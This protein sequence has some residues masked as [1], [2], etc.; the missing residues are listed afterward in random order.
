MEDNNF[1]GPFWERKIRTFFK[2]MDANGDGFV[3]KQDYQWLAGKYAEHGQLNYVQAKQV[4]RKLEKIWDDFYEKNSKNGDSD[5]KAY[6]KS[7]KERKSKLFEMCQ[8][9]HG[10]FFDLIDL[11]GDG[12]VQSEEFALF[13]KVFGIG[14]ETVA[15]ESFKKLDTNADGKLSH[16]E[17]LKAGFE[18][19]YS[20]DESLPSKHLYGPLV[21]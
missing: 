14:D 17:F 3:S 5:E 2:R 21:D 11:S 16:D 18:F 19:F 4:S 8:Q 1:G 12:I 13:F 7:L 20:G 10:L 15:A 6:I 9:F